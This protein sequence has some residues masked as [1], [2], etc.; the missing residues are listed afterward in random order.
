[1]AVE[2]EWEKRVES[3]DGIR[4]EGW[5]TEEEKLLNLTSRGQSHFQTCP[6]ALETMKLQEGVQGLLLEFTLKNEI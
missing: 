2:R 4:K 5:G 1:M 6:D 3:G